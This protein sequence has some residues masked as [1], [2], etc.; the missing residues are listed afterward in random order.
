MTGMLVF[1]RSLLL[2]HHGVDNGS[3]KKEGTDNTKTLDDGLY[4]HDFT[5]MIKS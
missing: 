5:L 2:G 4:V 3:K 1:A